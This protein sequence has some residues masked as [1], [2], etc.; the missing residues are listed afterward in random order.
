MACMDR[1]DVKFEDLKKFISEQRNFAEEFV[2]T[3]S[4]DDTLFCGEVALL[5]IGIISFSPKEA[6]NRP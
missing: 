3:A 5:F 1:S 2:T 6:F 4:P